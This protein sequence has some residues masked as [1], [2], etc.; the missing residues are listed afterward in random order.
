MQLAGPDDHP[1]E[2]G[3]DHLVA[4]VDDVAP[5][6]LVLV[7]PGRIVDTGRPTGNG[8]E[9][10]QFDDAPEVALFGGTEDQTVGSAP[11]SRHCAAARAVSAAPARAG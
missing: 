11:S 2:L 7:Q 4:P 10:H 6:A 8:A 5:G 9:N 1:V 3:H